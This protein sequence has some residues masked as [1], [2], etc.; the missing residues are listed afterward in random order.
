LTDGCC[1]SNFKTL[2]TNG[3]PFVSITHTLTQHVCFVIMT[4]HRENPMVS[5]QSRK[6]KYL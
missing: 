4:K 6:Y 1:F 5:S 2:L 3:G